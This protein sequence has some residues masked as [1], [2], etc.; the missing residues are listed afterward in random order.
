[1]ARRKTVG[2]LETRFDYNKIKFTIIDVGGQR[3]ERK[4]WLRCFNCI[5]AVIY[6]SAINEYDMVLEEDRSTNRLLESMKLW[7]ALSGSV[8]FKNTPFIL[9]LNKSDLFQAR[10]EKV[11]LS[12]VFEDYEDFASKTE[13]SKNT[14]FEKG[15][16]YILSKFAIYFDTNS[17]T[18]NF[19]PHVTNALDAKLCEKVFVSVQDT[20]VQMAFSHAMLV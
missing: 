5:T 17:G 10:I 18:H 1:L 9:F 13:V 15:W 20:V 19:Y 12:Q 14:E 4:K 3:S 7:K 6:L 2:I 8:F 16:K 11:P